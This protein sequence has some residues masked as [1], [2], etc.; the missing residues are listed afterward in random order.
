MRSGSLVSTAMMRKVLACRSRIRPPTDTCSRSSSV[1]SAAAPQTL[2]LH[3]SARSQRSHGGVKSDGAVQRIGTVHRFQFDQLALGFRAVLQR[4]GHGAHGDGFGDAAI[5]R[6]KCVL[7]RRRR[8]MHQLDRHIAAEQFAPLAAS[9]SACACASE[10]TPAMAATPSTRQA[11]KCESP[12]ARRAARAAPAAAPARSGS[13]GGHA[14]VGDHAAVLQP[15]DAVAAPRQHFFMRDEK[16]GGARARF[17]REQ[18]FGDVRAVCVSRLPV[19]SSANRTCGRG[20]MARA[21]A[22]RCCS[23][24]DSCPG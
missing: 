8:A 16:Q 23:P 17:Q 5:A 10:P 14:L 21:S 19:G 22:T 13:C 2:P 9:P 7:R 12:K 20:A 1:C 24:P 4:I 11:K 6:E 15:H 18:Q 3:A